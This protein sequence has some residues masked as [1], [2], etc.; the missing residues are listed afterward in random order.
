MARPKMPMAFIW[1]ISFS[2]YSLACSSSRTTGRT[3]RSTN[4]ATVSTTARSSADRLLI[5]PIRTRSAPMQE[6]P[7]FDELAVGQE[8]GRAPGLTLTSGLAA[9]H[10]AITGDRLALA[11]DHALCREVTGG[12]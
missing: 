5:S 7:Y 6:G 3:S 12:P 10:Q 1:P 4:S 2:G 8:F 9:V 11:T